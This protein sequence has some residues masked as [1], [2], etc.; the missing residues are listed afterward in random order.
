MLLAEL[1]ERPKRFVTLVDE[2]NVSSATIRNRIEDARELG[3]LY[4]DDNPSYNENANRIHPLT[5]KGE[6]VAAEIPVT[7]LTRI[8]QQIWDL[9]EEYDEKLDDFE[10]G[11]KEKMAEL[12]ED[13]QER[14]EES[15]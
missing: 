10:M 14:V 11:L 13:L 1:H 15:F 8:Q 12:N 4:D 7:D 6:T 9:Q 5:P 2:I 3:L